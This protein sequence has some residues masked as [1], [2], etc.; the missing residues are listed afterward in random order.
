MTV[1]V[2]KKWVMENCASLNGGYGSDGWNG[3]YLTLFNFKD[4]T[5]QKGGFAT[6]LTKS[7]K[8]TVERGFGGLN[9]KI[10]IPG[11]GW[12]NATGRSLNSGNRRY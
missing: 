1:K 10:L 2:S 12:A 4:I 8:E 11:R 6:N 5:A 7:Q 9:F 3:G